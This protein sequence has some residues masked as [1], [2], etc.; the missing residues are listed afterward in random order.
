MTR[1]LFYT[2][3]LTVAFIDQS[4]KM[5]VSSH[6]RPG[7]SIP[8]IDGVVL[9]EQ[10]RNPG[11]AF[12]IFQAYGGII[13]FLTA[14]AI[15]AI[16]VASRRDLVLPRIAWIALALQLGGAFGNLIDRI[17]LG[18]VLDFINFQVWPVFNFADAAITI[19]VVL[20]LCYV[21]FGDK[22]YARSAS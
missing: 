7:N 13:T 21:I 14:L 16:L 22:F 20:L 17:R 3:A 5:L 10:T 4:T 8:I 11:G 18:Y 1:R 19:G 15:I 2:I 12:G 9:I 6:L